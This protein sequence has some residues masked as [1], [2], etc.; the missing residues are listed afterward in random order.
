V[1]ETFAGLLFAVHSDGDSSVFN[2]LWQATCTLADMDRAVEFVYD[3]PGRRVRAAA[4]HGVAVDAVRDWQVDL[5]S[6]PTAL[7]ALD[8]DRVLEATDGFDAL[9]PA[10]ARAVSGRHVPVCTPVSATGRWPGVVFSDGS[11][12]RRLTDS[13]RHLL[14]SFSKP[15]ALADSARRATREH[16]RAKHLQERDRVIQRLFGVSLALSGE[17][18]SPDE[19]RR[20]GTEGAWRSPSPPRP[21]APPWGSGTRGGS[22]ARS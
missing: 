14:W 6:A 15:A 2:H 10:E 8:E 16:E 21:G 19:R 9:V 1:V 13:E 12:D 5:D 11:V 4:S 18:L 17:R 7:P 22:S 20:C 3:A